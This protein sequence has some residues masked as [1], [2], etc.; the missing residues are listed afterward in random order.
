M[1]KTEQPLYDV[2]S[3][4][5][6]S[7]WNPVLDENPVI[8]EQKQKALEAQDEFAKALEQRYAQ[9]NWF[10]VAAGFAKPQLGGFMAS[11]GS[12]SQA[13]GENVEQQRAIA[14]TIA[15]MRAEVAQGRIGLETNKEQQRMIA[16]YDNKG[17]PN[18]NELRRIYSANPNSDVAKSIEK[19]PE[20]EAAR[21]TETGFG[22]DIQERLQ[23]NPSLRII[24]DPT[25]KG[26]EVSPEQRD[27]FVNSVNKRPDFVPAENWN[28]MGFTDRLDAHAKQAATS[29]EQGM[30]EG[31]KSAHEAQQSHDVLDELTSI[32]R[33]AVDPS[34]KPLFSLYQNG[35][36][37][38]QFRAFL[39]KNPGNVQAAVEGLVAA[40]MDK[41]KNAD[42]ATRAKA[43][44]LIK[45]IANVEIGL[46]STL[47][48]PTDAISTLSS[49]RSPSLMNSQAGF[50]GIVD[51]LGLNAYRQIEMNQL[52]N[53]LGLSDRKLLSADE[54]RKFR[55]QTREL[56]EKLASQVSLDQTPSWFYPGSTQ[57]AP[58]P[59]SPAPSAAPA[60]PAAAKPSAASSGKGTWA[61]LQAWKN[62]QQPQP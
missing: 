37:F 11:L 58:A 42:E 61:Q 8:A 13:L 32:R 10:K 26:A 54:M 43:D 22:L 39:D 50:V 5:D 35:D 55:N 40:S 17:V 27:A 47:N 28:A 14:P 45:G 16:D 30:S 53:E 6:L 62:Q 41:L 31:Q 9:P 38:S 60:A 44:K 12:A 3:V 33:L 59:A 36:L 2:K 20:W 57:A 18:I 51:Q 49:A 29:M 48:N 56:R 46:R 23:K 52:R 7:K 4:L 24:N 21:R 34:L 1:E 15:R 25:Y 19:R